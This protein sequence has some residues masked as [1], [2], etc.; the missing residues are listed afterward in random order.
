MIQGS[1]LALN[2]HFKARVELKDCVGTERRHVYTHSRQLYDDILDF[3][4]LCVFDGN[5]IHNFMPLYFFPC[6]H[7][8]SETLFNVSMMKPRGQGG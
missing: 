5:K 2:P 3:F 7:I 6:F 8:G 1:P 4:F